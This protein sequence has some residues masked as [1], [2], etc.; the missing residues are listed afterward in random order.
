IERDTDRDRFMSAEDARVY[1]LV[2]NV[3]QH[4]AE[5]VAAK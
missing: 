4:Q 5:L 1:G 2:D 3:I